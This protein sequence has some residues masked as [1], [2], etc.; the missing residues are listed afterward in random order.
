[1]ILIDAG[2]EF[3][4]YASDITRTFPANGHFSPAQKTLYN[5]VLA[6]QQAALDC[7]HP[8]SRYMDGHHAALRF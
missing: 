8:G 2:C 6:A 3:N 7:A 1:L 4:S 5:I